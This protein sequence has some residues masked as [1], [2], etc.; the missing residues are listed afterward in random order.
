ML[1]RSIENAP[2]FIR[3]G[4]QIADAL[5][6]IGIVISKYV[7]PPLKWLIKNSTNALGGLAGGVAGW[8]SRS[9]EAGA[10]ADSF[11]E[12][13][14]MWTDAFGVTGGANPIS[15]PGRTGVERFSNRQSELNA[16]A[17]RVLVEVKSDDEMFETEVK[18][19]SQGEIA[20][21]DRQKA[22]RGRRSRPN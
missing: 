19:I 12:A 7:I 17:Q 3:L 5:L 8:M 14:G 21:S 13:A 4:T 10:Q 16:R 18:D 11:G 20:K 6:D 1:F 22:R 15:S 2:E 9:E